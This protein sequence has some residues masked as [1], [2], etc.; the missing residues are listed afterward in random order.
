[1][2]KYKRLSLNCVK[3]LYTDLLLSHQLDQSDGNRDVNLDGYCYLLWKY[4]FLLDTLREPWVG[5][6]FTGTKFLNFRFTQEIV[7]MFDDKTI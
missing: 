1:M 5:W 3:I 6:P 7:L 2:I 4:T